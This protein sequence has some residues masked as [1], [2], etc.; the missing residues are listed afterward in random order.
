MEAGMEER[1]HKA[2]GF[3]IVEVLVVTVLVA[4]SVS[5]GVLQ[6][7]SSIALI[8]ADKAAN[9]VTAQILYARQ[10]AIAQRRNVLVSFEDSNEIKVIR[11]DGGGE[12]TVMADVVLPTG[13]TFSM[14][15]DL[16]DTP[17]AFGNAGPVDF[18]TTNGGKFLA[19]GIFV[20][21]T[22]DVMNGTVFTMNGSSSTARAVTLSGASGRL[23]T[24]RLEGDAWTE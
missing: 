17:D 9:L 19:D 18:D 7:K 20:N 11:Q 16:E 2:R 6:M 4:V 22:G 8:D 12:T 10:V 21:D 23:R 3:S 15:D 1:S 13:F 24:Y 14:P 5:V